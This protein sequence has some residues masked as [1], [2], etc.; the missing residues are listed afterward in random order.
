[1]NYT[2]PRREGVPLVPDRR[3]LETTQRRSFHRAATGAVLAA[4]NRDATAE[5]IISK[6]WPSDRE[7]ILLTRAPSTPTSGPSIAQVTTLRLLAPPSAAAKLFDHP[8]AIKLDFAGVTTYSIPR[9]GSAPA[10]LFIA[11]GQPAPVVAVNYAGTTCGPP[12]KLM[13]MAGL[14]NEL[15]DATPEAASTLIGATLSEAATK[16]FDAAVFSATAADTT[17]P[18]GIFNGV[19]PITAAA[20]GSP[21]IALATDLGKL[22]QAI[23]DAGISTADIVVVA[24]AAAAT[25]LRLLA[26]PTWEVPIYSTGAMGATSVAMIAPAGIA[27]GYSG[28]PSIDTTKQA[29]LVFTN[30]GVPVVD[31]GSATGPT[32]S[33]FQM[34][35]LAL[36]VRVDCA[37][38]AL[39]GAVQLVNN[40]NW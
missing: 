29:E 21:D 8:A 36:R 27:T 35:L 39:P 31:G 32:Y 7:A 2:A 30:P 19:T 28:A 18:A 3:A 11:E 10:P 1:M 26:S 12:K 9:V 5:R 40:I 33:T 16:A 20:A 6:A 37:W 38:C 23:S 24:G 34:D 14:S 22:A 15:Q 17:R 25:K 4:F 13:F